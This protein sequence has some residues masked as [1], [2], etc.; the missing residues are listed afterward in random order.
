MGSMKLVQEVLGALTEGAEASQA[1]IA[2]PDRHCGA[3]VNVFT[4]G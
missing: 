3:G 1:P 4:A 2:I